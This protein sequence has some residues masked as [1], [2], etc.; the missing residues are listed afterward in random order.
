VYL[1]GKFCCVRS[2][3]CNPTLHY[4]PTGKERGSVYNCTLYTL[5]AN[6]GGYF[7]KNKKN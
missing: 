2:D 3:Q 5:N 4:T 6:P 1:D 7:Q